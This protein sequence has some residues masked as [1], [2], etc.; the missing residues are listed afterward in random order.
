MFKKKRTRYRVVAKYLRGGEMKSKGF[1]RGF[2]ISNNIST[3]RRLFCNKLENKYFISIL[4]RQQNKVDRFPLKKN[5]I[6][7]YVVSFKVKTAD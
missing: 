7:Q 5:E 4:P 2:C 6:C 3:P 1:N